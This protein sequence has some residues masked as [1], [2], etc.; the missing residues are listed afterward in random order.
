M[1]KESYHVWI[2]SQFKHISGTK[3]Q[4]VRYITRAGQTF[5]HQN[6]RTI[7]RKKREGENPKGR[8]GEREA[9]GGGPEQ[10]RI[11]EEVGRGAQAPSRRYA[12]SVFLR[13]HFLRPDLAIRRWFLMYLKSLQFLS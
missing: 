2:L 7:T 11:H 1:G 9:N 8:R 12:S 3:S 13:I 4:T 6:E 10:D 5:P